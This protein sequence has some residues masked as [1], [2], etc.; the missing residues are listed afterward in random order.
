MNVEVTWR[1]L[2]EA[3]QHVVGHPGTG[4]KR[5]GPDLGVKDTVVLVLSALRVC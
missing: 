4:V 5:R 2:C 1:C 3:S